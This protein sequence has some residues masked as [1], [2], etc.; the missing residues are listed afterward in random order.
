LDIEQTF[1]MILKRQEKDGVIKAMYDSSNVLGS[2]Y[3]TNTSNLDLIFKSG[4][5]Y[6]YANVSKSDYTRLEIAE[7][8]GQIFNTHIKKY[9]AEEMEKVDTSKILEEAV[10]L[11]AKEDNAIYEAIKLE[12]IEK[13]K[14]A[15]HDND[16]ITLGKTTTNEAHEL[17][18]KTL[19][20]IQLLIN[21]FLTTKTQEND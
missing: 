2:I 5:K 16:V 3:D 20:E 15:C 14:Y 9:A 11:K 8:Q 6:R 7:S 4:Q 1:N 21:N 17:F 19:Q 13:I 10:D 18:G 12:L